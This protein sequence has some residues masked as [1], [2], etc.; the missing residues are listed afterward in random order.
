MSQLSARRKMRSHPE[1]PRVRTTVPSL[2]SFNEGD[3]ADLEIT[4][5]AYGG[6]GIGRAR[7]FVFLV[8]RALPGEAVRVRIVSR[9]PNYAEAEVVE[10]LR[11][12]P[13]ALRPRC[14]SFAECGGCQW[15]NMAYEHQLD[16]KE[17][18]VVEALERVG[19]LGEFALHR[20][21]RSP[22]IYHYRNK[23]ELA[24]SEGPEGLTLGFH[25][26][27][28]DKEIVDIPTCLIGTERMDEIARS[29]RSLL[30]DK[31]Y[32]PAPEPEDGRQAPPGTRERDPRLLLKHLV[33]REG[34]RTGEVLV[35]LVT[36]PGHMPEE[37]ELARAL[38]ERCPYVVGVV[39]TIVHNE[40]GSQGKQDRLLAGRERVRE[41]LCGIRYDIA[42]SAFFQVN[43]EQ[44]ETLYTRTRELALPRGRES[45]LDLY[46]GVGGLTLF[47]ATRARRVTGVESSPEAVRCAGANASLN[48]VTNVRF[49]QAEA[50]RFARRL[51]A[52]KKNY[53]VVT[54]NP[55][56]S[57]V[58]EDM[59]DSIPEIGPRRIVYVSCNPATLAR[60]LSGL[61][62]RGYCLTD[63]QPVDMFPHSFHVETIARLERTN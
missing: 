24:F 5:L 44:A 33:V 31:R 35:N 27:G 7:G 59:I 63:V 9:K 8:R 62:S 40:R 47:L 16:V 15:M 20:I 14:L 54:I 6:A 52:T 55:P 45:V 1:T 25:R 3:L 60:D 19:G 21:L 11:P 26:V 36:T 2:L 23:L 17:G 13:L 4:D 39:R 43:T 58:H 28:S 53:D 32:G 49:V 61:C 57:G 22:E 51:A 41:L 50:R 29:A 34:R 42:A 12:S 10:R 37:R 18:L 38:M 30:A 48:G 56:R 46:C